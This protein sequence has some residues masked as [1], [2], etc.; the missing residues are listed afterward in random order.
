M[1]LSHPALPPGPAAVLTAWRLCPARSRWGTPGSPWGAAAMAGGRPDFTA[2]RAGGAH[3]PD[4]RREG[5]RRG[6]RETAVPAAKGPWAG[7]GPWQE[8]QTGRQAGSRADRRCR[9]RGAAACGAP[10]AGAGQGR[11]RSAPRPPPRALPPAASR[12]SPAAPPPPTAGE[13]GRGG[14]GRER[15]RLPWKGPHRPVSRG[16]KRCS[17]S[18]SSRTAGVGPGERVLGV[19]P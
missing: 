3:R 5:K 17:L 13:A 16:A 18:C 15:P 9:L 7:A 2:G 19:R 10:V 6:S 1:S 11:A 14:E 4:E 12:G 8:R